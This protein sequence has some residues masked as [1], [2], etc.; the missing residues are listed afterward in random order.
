MKFWTEIHIVIIRYSTIIILN[1]FHMSENVKHQF[2]EFIT[3]LITCSMHY[4]LFTIFFFNLNSRNVREPAGCVVIVSTY[5]IPCNI[6]IPN[7]GCLFLLPCSLDWSNVNDH[8]YIFHTCEERRS[9]PSS[10]CFSF[11]DNNKSRIGNAPWRDWVH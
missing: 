6:I 8:S 3:V 5:S 7:H 2:I 1:T 10:F 9:V 4:M 11:S